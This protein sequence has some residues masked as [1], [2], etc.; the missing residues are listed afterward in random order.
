MN[1]GELD[2][3]RVVGGIVLGLDIGEQ[4][5]LGEKFLHAAELKRELGELLNLVQPALVVVVGFLEII[6]VARVHDEAQHLGGV[7]ARA[8]G[9]ELRNGGDKLRP[10]DGGFFRH[11]LGA[12]LEGGGNFVGDDVRRL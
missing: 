11:H 12:G 6:V 4:G 8:L 5:E 3:F 7:A 2:F 1:G 9:F 10:R